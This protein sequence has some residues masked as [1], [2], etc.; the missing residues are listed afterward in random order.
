MSKCFLCK[1]EITNFEKNYYQ[2]C[3]ECFVKENKDKPLDGSWTRAATREREHHAA[4]I[5]Q[6]VDRY[7][8]VNKKFRELYGDK[9]IQKEY[10]KNPE[11]ME[12]LRKSI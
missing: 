9:T 11:V 8:G 7:G 10:K 3:G 2:Q 4:D 12:Q 6:P 5:M 1:K